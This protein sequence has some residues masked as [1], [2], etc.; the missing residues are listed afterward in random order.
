MQNLNI[1]SP[2]HILEF[3]LHDR[4]SCGQSTDDVTMREFLDASMTFSK[5]CRGTNHATILNRLFPHKHEYLIP[6]NSCSINRK[7]IEAVTNGCTT[8]QKLHFLQYSI[9]YERQYKVE[10]VFPM[11]ISSEFSMRQHRN[12]NHQEDAPHFTC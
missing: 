10:C 5:Q 8:T 3:L 4:N 11:V 2:V 6:V 9:D 7:G 1:R 12:E